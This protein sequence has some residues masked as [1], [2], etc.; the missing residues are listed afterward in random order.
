MIVY[1]ITNIIN[2]KVYIGQTIMTLEE[3]FYFHCNPSKDNKMLICRSIKK[4]GKDNFIK[5]I[6]EYCETLEQSNIRE[7]YWVNYYDARNKKIGYNI[8]PG[9]GN[10]LKTE[11]FRKRISEGIKNSEKAK[12]KVIWNKGL[13]AENNVVLKEVADRRRYKKRSLVTKKLMSIAK[14]GKTYEEIYGVNADIMKEKRK[15]IIVTDSFKDKMSDISTQRQA[16]TVLQ[17]DLQTNQVVKEFN[18]VR[19]ALLYFN[20]KRNGGQIASV[21]NKRTKSFKGFGWRYKSVV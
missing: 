19:D 17:I 20:V 16:R 7:E 3:R 15:N 8:R 9:G 1:K 4:Y 5:E 13:T 6:I 2:N 21:I 14:K 11:E 18:S 10:S 12:N